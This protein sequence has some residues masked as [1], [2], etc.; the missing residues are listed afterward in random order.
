MKYT[1]IEQKMIRRDIF[2]WLDEKQLAGQ[3][4][5]SREELAEYSWQGQ[6]MRL[7][8][9]Q[10]GIWNP[11]S[12]DA[13]LSIL[14]TRNGPYEDKL[15]EGGLLV[16][17]A[18][19]KAEGG[20]NLKLIEAH[21]TQE[22][23]IYFTPS[24]EARGN[25]YVANYPVF[26]AEVDHANREF[27]IAMSEEFRLFADPLQSGLDE[28][29]WAE[30]LVLARVHQPRFRAMVMSAYSETCAVCHLKHVQL[31]DAAH[32]I[33]DTHELGKAVVPNG[34]SLCKIHH[35][36]YDSNFLGITPDFEVRINAALLEEVDG[37]ML[38]H[39]LQEMH[40]RTLHLPKN[41]LNW[42]GKEN[43]EFRFERFAA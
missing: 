25:R 30:R 18:F 29:K 20:T 36:A 43:L 19:A 8:D 40:G 6:K 37:P 39:G 17:Y 9:P 34:L 42:P 41:E 23:L 13:T 27:V 12:F 7:V 24:V 35:A 10:G 14:S 33:P 16:R 31:L 1:E 28:R 15:E 21:R 22:P 11:A 38:K 4:D 5:F 3:Y 32:I 2:R 26:V